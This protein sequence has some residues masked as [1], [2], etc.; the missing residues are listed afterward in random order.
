M[1]GDWNATYSQLPATYNI[2]MVNMSAPPSII[3][4]GWLADI[5]NTYNLM[6]PFRAFH[7][8]L[9]DFTFFP[10]RK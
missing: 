3:R 9:R 6:D 4:A 2:D 10:K 1:G 8:I 5:C 7:P